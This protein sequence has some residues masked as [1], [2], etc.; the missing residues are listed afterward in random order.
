MALR[1]A[2]LGGGFPLCYA[3]SCAVRADA[4]RGHRQ[5]A[6]SVADRWTAAYPRSRRA[7]AGPL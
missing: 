3:M 1:R 4:T 7:S 5:F 2:A 6:G